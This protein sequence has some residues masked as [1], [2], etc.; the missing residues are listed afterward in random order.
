MADDWK[1]DTW[2]RYLPQLH[3][4]L[5]APGIETTLP[6]SFVSLNADDSRAWWET[7]RYLFRVLL[8]WRCLPAGLAW[9]YEQ[10]RPDLGDARLR[11]ALERW[12]TREELDYFAAREWETRGQ[13]GSPP[14]EVLW[15][16]QDFEPHPGWRRELQARHCPMDYSPYGG[17][18]N[19][20]HL[21]H[22]DMVGDAAHPNPPIGSHDI[23][24]RRAMVVT[25][26]FASWRHDLLRFSSTLPRLDQRSWHVDVFD[27]EV[28]LLGTFRQSQ[29][30]GLWFQ[31][32]HSIHLSG[33]PSHSGD[34][35]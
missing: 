8:G 20:M 14:F 25:N 31:G 27:R 12:N 24:S 30:T 19:P 3:R 35:D 5:A 17:G 21:G 28:G 4:Q 34:C 22:S 11:F 26:S 1:N 13:T 16:I 23:K 9:W 2:C 7:L 29:V 15:K 33:N 6:R 18:W 32:A 10:G